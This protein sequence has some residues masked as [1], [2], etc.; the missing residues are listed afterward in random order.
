VLFR[1]LLIAAGRVVSVFAACQDLSDVPCSRTVYDALFTAIALVSQNVW[2]W[3]H[4]KLAKNK[5]SEEPQLFL[6]L[7]RVKEMLLWIT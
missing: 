5:H 1:N 4:F 7:L 6:E 3:I 2:G